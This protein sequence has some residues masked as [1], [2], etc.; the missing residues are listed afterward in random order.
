MIRQK[1]L[2]IILLLHSIFHFPL[3]LQHQ[4]KDLFVS[5]TSPLLVIW[6]SFLPIATS[7]EAFIAA[8]P[9]ICYF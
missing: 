3:L 9:K 6:Y 2:T 4:F 8:L 5:K 1:C 7:Q